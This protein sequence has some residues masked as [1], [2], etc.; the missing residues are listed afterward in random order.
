MRYI[1][2]LVTGV[3][4]LCGARAATIAVPENLAPWGISASQPADAR[5][6][7]ADFAEAM[8]AR[9]GGQL[10]IRFV[11]YGR[12]LQEVRTGSADYAFGVVGPATSDAAPFVT[13]VA[14]APMVAVA[15]KGLALRSLA[16]LHG[17]AEVGYLRGGSCGP[18][19]DSDADVKRTAQDSYDAAIR[20]LAAGRLDGWCSIQPGFI[21]ALR[22]LK[23]EQDIGDQL[24][25]S[26]VRIGFQVTRAKADAPEGRAMAGLVDQLVSEGVTGKIFERYV[27]VAFRP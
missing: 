22:T 21:Y 2:L 7:Y 13:T 17:F 25:Y 26:E 15:R 9:A 24:A 5:G 27:G 1:I 18:L 20:K 16:D 14:K 6:I 10:D 23:L 12:M 19:I 4:G 8:A 11:P 3:L